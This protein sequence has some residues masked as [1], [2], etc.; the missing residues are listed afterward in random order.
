MQRKQ[1]S[2]H[3]KCVFF[4]LQTSSETS[5][6]RSLT[7]SLTQQLPSVPQFPH[8]KM[9]TMSAHFTCLALCV[10]QSLAVFHRENCM[11]PFRSCVSLFQ[12]YSFGYSG[13][14][15]LPESLP[16]RYSQ[17]L[18]LE[19]VLNAVEC[20]GVSYDAELEAGL[21]LKFLYYFFKFPALRVV[22]FHWLCKLCIL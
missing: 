4:L 8:L 20:A 5:R 2:K 9:G 3:R 22:G 11:H 6:T 14:Q 7:L 16:S 17:R 18:P 1:P 10:A 21:F 19:G 12:S 15:T 13:L